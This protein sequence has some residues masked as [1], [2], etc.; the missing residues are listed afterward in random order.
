LNG[1]TLNGVTS[2]AVAS[3]ALISNG[4]TSNVV[5]SKN[6]EIKNGNLALKMDHF[7]GGKI[8]IQCPNHFDLIFPC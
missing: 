5:T 3:N 4:V 6:W 8:L 2:N 1:V 7:E